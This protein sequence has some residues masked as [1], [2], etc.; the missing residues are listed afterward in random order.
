M[1]TFLVILLSL[2]L[3][4]CSCD[5]ENTTYT[6]KEI[7]HSSYFYDTPSEMV[8][9]EKAEYSYSVSLFDDTMTA[10]SESNPLTLEEI[11]TLTMQLQCDSTFE[12]NFGI[13]LLSSYN[14][15]EYCVEQLTDRFYCYSV[16][17]SKSN[18]AELRLTFSPVLT[19][20]VNSLHI[21]LIENSD[22]LSTSLPE[23]KDFSYAFEIPILVNQKCDTTF[24]DI[25]TSGDQWIDDIYD[26][27][28]YDS[29]SQNEQDFINTNIAAVKN[30]TLNISLSMDETPSL[31]TKNTLISSHSE[32]NSGWLK[33]YGQAGKY[34]TIIFIDNIPLK[35][36]NDKYCLVWNAADYNKYLNAPFT[37]QNISTGVHTVY[38]LT[39]ALDSSN[40]QIVY[41]SYKI[42]LLA[43]EDPSND[44]SILDNAA[45]IFYDSSGNILESHEDVINC[46]S[47][48]IFMDFSHSLLES[49][50]SR[51]YNLY[52]LCNGIIQDFS[53]NNAVVTSHSY[54]L[55]PKENCTLT[56]KFTPTIT[57]SFVENSSHISLDILFLPELENLQN[58]DLDNTTAFHRRYYLDCERVSISENKNIFELMPSELTSPIETLSI[59][60]STPDAPKIEYKF[61]G[62]YMKN[63]SVTMHYEASGLPQGS[64][65]V[66]AFSNGKMM[67]LLAE[68]KF[69]TYNIDSPYQKAEFTYTL[70]NTVDKKIKVVFLT[71][72]LDQNITRKSPIYYNQLMLEQVNS[73]E[74]STG[75]VSAYRIFDGSYK[76]YV[77]FD[78]A[79]VPNSY[80]CAYNYIHRKADESMLSYG[81]SDYMNSFPILSDKFIVE[82]FESPSA[83]IVENVM[84]IYSSRDNGFTV[85][86]YRTPVSE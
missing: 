33:C 11:T 27:F 63:N 8:T 4:L 24:S 49:Y 30:N 54:T 31:N 69:I 82:Y 60:V 53:L 67:D 36:F 26:V 43:L 7:K 68:T 6:Y 22:S 84:H 44:G 76:N 71:I 48:E 5:S 21:I 55:N 50:L 77:S 19:S 37:F 47:D 65:I 61:M 51:N 59:S 17:S 25:I 2:L 40:K 57:K 56:I 45:V 9:N 42:G 66:F 62:K 13:I 32:N 15:I 72:S 79:L 1:K 64:Y 75:T 10:I 85:T 18:T 35:A 3:I 74:T 52:I 86:K 38:A 14:P 80:C 58:S 28:G 41:D 29:L 12:V 23:E 16:S 83:W 78:G 70:N 39:I 34:A 81:Y 20:D 46:T 73:T